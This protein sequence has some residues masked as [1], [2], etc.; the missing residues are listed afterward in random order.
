MAL[1]RDDLRELMPDTAAGVHEPLQG[2]GVN[3]RRLFKLR[4]RLMAI[5]LLAIAIPSAAAILFF[6]PQDYVA[7][8]DI[9]FKASNPTIMLAQSGSAS[10][11]P[12]YESFVNTQIKLITGYTILSRVLQD[13]EVR[14]LP[15]FRGR[16]GDALSRTMKRIE[17]EVQNRT[18]LVTFT[19]RDED[20]ETARFML[21]KIMTRYGDYLAEQE[22]EQGERR[23]GILKDQEQVLSRSLEL[24][25]NEVAQM[26]KEQGVPVSTNV[27]LDPVETESN[28]INLAQAEADI[29]T[30]QTALKQTER[31]RDRVSDLLAEHHGSPGSPIFALNVEEKVLANPSVTLLLEQLAVVQQEFSALTETYVDNAPQLE[32]KRQELNGVEAE[33]EKVKMQARADALQSLLGQYEYET[34]VHESDLSDAQQRRE[35]F[36]AL[37]EDQREENLSRAGAIAEIE[38]MERRIDDT[39]ENLR[40]LRNTLLS[41]DIE[42]NAP[43][44]ANILGQATVTDTPDQTERIKYIL[45]MLFIAVLVSLMTGLAIEQLDQNIRSAED[46][47]YVTGLPILASIAHTAEDRLPGDVNVAT[48]TEDYPDSYTTDEFR[49]TVGRILSVTPGREPI[50]TCIIAS[51]ARGDGKTTLACNMAIVMAQA[52]RRVL[53]VDVDSRTPSVEE[54]FGLTPGAGLAELLLGEDVPHDP[55][56]K[57]PHANLHVIG[58]GLRS[59]G[60]IERIASREMEDFLAGAEEVFDQIIIDT[61][62]SLLMSE[63]KLL[64]P[65]CDA[66]VVVSGAG[67]SS[68]G[69]L[70]RTLR[71]LTESRGNVLGIV[72]NAVRHAPGGY[73][74]RNISQYYA[75]DRGHQRATTH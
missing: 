70:R 38:A 4:G 15:V 5:I 14:N 27:G 56:R 72:V 58:P 28:R 13:E 69:M 59:N 33:L 67:V 55:A 22:R 23:R 11:T 37:L 35:K 50:K 6:V 73:M 40:Q 10:G 25:R 64:A 57:T 74:R 21:D 3:V 1:S 47:G 16:E 42:S 36:A 62:A 71:V 17:A 60:L 19:Y 52:G 7:T 61:P 12:A 49:R 53:L 9:E 65:I 31:L 46:V 63:A 2:V 41:I 44:R 68:F 39:R 26:R 29:S 32:V 75:Q 24:Q 18:E 45:V 43:A 30:A 66:I 34:T 8:A 20:R 51:P 48:V 54:R